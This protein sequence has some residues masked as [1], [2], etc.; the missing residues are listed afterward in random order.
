M[1]IA[2]RM[3]AFAQS[4]QAQLAVQHP[5]VFSQ[6]AQLLAQLGQ[7]A[8]DEG[9]PGA[10]PGDSDAATPGGINPKLQ[11]LL[12]PH[13]E[14]LAQLAAIFAQAPSVGTPTAQQTASPPADGRS[15]GQ[16]QMA[17]SGDESSGGNHEQGGSSA[18]IEGASTCEGQGRESATRAERMKHEHAPRAPPA[19]GGIA[20]ANVADSAEVA[21]PDDIAVD[22]TAPASLGDTPDSGECSDAA[23]NGDAAGSNDPA[24][25]DA[26]ADVNAAVPG[27]VAT[28]DATPHHLVVDDA[29]LESD[30]ADEP[31][32]ASVHSE[33]HLRGPQGK[34]VRELHKLLHDFG[35]GSTIGVEISTKTRQRG[36]ATAPPAVAS[37]LGA[38]SELQ[39]P[40][41]QVDATKAPLKKRPK[42][43][44][45]DGA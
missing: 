4:A 8:T 5:D 33:W 37:S 16:K 13:P 2:S 29:G 20:D 1:S 43:R 24:S 26:A 22:A 39:S 3:A 9:A 6:L 36:T 11:E 14:L 40:A 19:P 38:P 18:G 32:A 41:P 34:G 21:A 44:G 15:A 31:T 35:D 30:D 7:P 12:S 42:L 28:D 17:D 25:D 27:D 10:A 23:D 45:S